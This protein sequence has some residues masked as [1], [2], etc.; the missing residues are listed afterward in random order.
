MEEIKSKLLEIL[1]GL[2]PDE[3]IENC[4]TLVDGK[5]LDSFDGFPVPYLL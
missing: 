5:V 3:D 1:E 2:H 4:T